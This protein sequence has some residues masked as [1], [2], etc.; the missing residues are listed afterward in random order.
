[1]TYSDKQLKENARVGMKNVDPADIRPPAI[2]LCQ[3]LTDFS[4][5]I[6][7][8]GKQAEIGQYFNTGKLEIYNSF[9]CY[10]LY[11]GKSKYTDRRQPEKGEQDQYKVLGVMADDFTLF[12]MTFKGSARYTLSGLFGTAAANQR[13]MYSYLI[14]M[15]TKE[16][17]GEKG[18]W[19]VPVCRIVRPEAD[20]EKLS[21]LEDQA[22]AFE[23]RSEGAEQNEEYEDRD[24]GEPEEPENF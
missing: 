22:K 20:P 21:L 13:P 24:E 3:K 14:R 16:I 6:D 18:E 8:D 7:K 17:S 19:I 11:A 1:M 5:M 15:E 10:I 23:N 9:E 4:L 12:G 2:L